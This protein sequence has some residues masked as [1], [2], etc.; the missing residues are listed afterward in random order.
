M[1]ESLVSRLSNSPELPQMRA[2]GRVQEDV[3]RRKRIPPCH[4]EFRGPRSDYVKQ[5]ALATALQIDDCL[6]AKWIWSRIRWWYV[7]STSSSA[8]EDM[9]CRGADAR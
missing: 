1:K 9:P 6:L 4:D 7:R 3:R 5:V 8:T 2:E